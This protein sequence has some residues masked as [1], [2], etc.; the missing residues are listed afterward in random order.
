MFSAVP[1]ITKLLFKVEVPTN[2]PTT[3]PSVFSHPRY[4]LV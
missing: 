1:E 4:H 2:I 3:G